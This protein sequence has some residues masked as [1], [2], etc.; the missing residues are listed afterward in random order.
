MESEGTGLVDLAAIGREYPQFGKSI[1]NTGRSSSQVFG[2]GGCGGSCGRSGENLSGEPC[3]CG[4]EGESGAGEWGCAGYWYEEDADCV[5]DPGSPWIPEIELEESCPPLVFPEDPPDSSAVAR[6]KPG[7]TDVDIDDECTSKCC[8]YHD[9]CF[10]AMGCT[11]TS[12]VN[13]FVT[14]GCFTC[15]WV[16]ANCVTACGLGYDTMPSY[17]PAGMQLC[18]TRECGGNYYCTDSCE[19]DPLPRWGP[20]VANPD[21]KF[22]PWLGRGYSCK[23][24]EWFDWDKC[25]CVKS[26][27]GQYP[28]PRK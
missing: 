4:C 13:P 9:R 18:Y 21:P 27:C 15:N 2:Q 3:S 19:D 16:V 28:D 22:D 6:D 8:A 10:H 20:G 17:C 23:A 24:G 12:W 5:C 11:W 14:L 25:R 7:C 1:W 26:D